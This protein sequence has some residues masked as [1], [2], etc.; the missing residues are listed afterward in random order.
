MPVRGKSH[1][2]LCLRGFR[3]ARCAR[4]IELL[5]S[6][7]LLIMPAACFFFFFSLKARRAPLLLFLP[8]RHCALRLD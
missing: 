2:F 6:R 4:S 3:A 5:V 8:K 1:L 7:A